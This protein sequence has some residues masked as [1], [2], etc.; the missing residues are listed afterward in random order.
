MI[1]LMNWL[2]SLFRPN[3]KRIFL[4][5]ASATPMLAEVRRAMEKYESKL[6]YN[7]GAIYQEALEAKNDIESSRK[8]IAELVGAGQKEIIFTASGTESINLAILGTFEKA[9]EEVKTPHIIISSIEHPAVVRVAEECVRRGG[10]L[11]VC[12]VDENGVISIEH[13]KKILK[14]NT[15]LVSVALANSEIG[16]IQPLSKIGRLLKEERKKRN[17]EYPILHTDASATPSYLNVNLEQLQCDLITLDG[18]KIYGPKSIAVLAKR[19]WVKLHPIIF[20]G[21]QEKGRRAGTLSP[22]LIAGLKVALEIAVHD[23]EKE[24]ERLLSLRQT[25]I[26]KIIKNLPQA[27]I[28][29]SS[30]Y[31]L[32]NIVSI[33]MPGVLSEFLALKLDR[34]GV[35]VSVGTACSYDER[36]SGSPIIKALGKDELKESTIRFSFGRQTTEKELNR[37]IDLFCQS[38]QNMVE[39]SHATIQPLYNQG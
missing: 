5:Y 7:P 29:G 37:A 38:V 23:R 33:S 10:E 8:R 6:F 19:A 27:I 9:I 21:S 16:T 3:S 34:E 12:E 13:L 28:N 20:G 24:G 39:S 14:K 1:T 17:S 4:D 18:S 32:P 36:E 15:V 11:S 22:G 35:L 25:F 26:N 30:E 2:K 31:H